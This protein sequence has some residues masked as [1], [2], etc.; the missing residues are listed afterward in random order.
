V[1]PLTALGVAGF[2]RWSA[3]RAATWAGAV[4]N[5][6]FGLIKAAIMTAAVA[7]RP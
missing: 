6:V 2:R 5:S 7:R 3:Y 4:T 1:T